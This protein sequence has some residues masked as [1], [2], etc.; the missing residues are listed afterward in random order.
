MKLTL[1]K[2][3]G[4]CD[5]SVYV[6]GKLVS[7]RREVQPD[8]K[9]A[10][11]ALLNA[12]GLTDIFIVKRHPLTFEGW[13]I[14]TALLWLFGIFGIFS[15]RLPKRFDRL[16]YRL[17]GD[18]KED[19]TMVLSVESPRALQ[20][21]FAP[22]RVETDVPFTE[23]NNRWFFDVKARKRKKGYKIFNMIFWLAAALSAV[24]AIFTLVK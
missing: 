14:R 17:T 7:F 20:P 23:E 1:F 15:P 3:G 22:V 24:I 11:V 18:V 2:R 16:E 10:D 6:G 19:T 9:K 21:D 13:L 8:G 4:L 12:D 5:A